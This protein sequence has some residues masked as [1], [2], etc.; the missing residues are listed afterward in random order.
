MPSGRDRKIVHNS[1]NGFVYGL[2]HIANILISQSPG[3]GSLPYEFVRLNIDHVNVQC[4]FCV[5]VYARFIGDAP[6]VTSPR[7]KNGSR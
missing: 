6:T 7:V 1:R 4:T 3:N 2:L 5:L